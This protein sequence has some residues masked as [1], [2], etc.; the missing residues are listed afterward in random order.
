VRKRHSAYQCIDELCFQRNCPLVK[1]FQRL[2]ESLFEDGGPYVEL[3]R[4]IAKYRYGIG[5]AELIAKSQLPDGGYTVSRLHQLEKAGFITSLV[6]YGRKDKGLYYVIDDEYSLFYLYWMEPKSKVIS[7]K[8]I[9]QGFWLAQANQPAW[10]T[11]AAL[12]FESTCY[13]HIDQIHQ[14]LKID[15]GASSETWR[16]VPKTAQG[17]GAQIDLLFDGLD[18]AIT[19]CEIKYSEKPFAI[20]KSYAQEILKKMELFK[21]QTKTKKQ[22]F[23]SI[24]TTMGLKPTMYSEELISS[25]ATLDDLFKNI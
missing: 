23:F 18:G 6:S 22:L 5:Q 3:I 20:D 8:C 24:I 1:E 15:P 25:E 9:N 12:S 14:A 7:R 4:T 16:F 11:W 21:Q 17:E 13:K 10:K 19:L 2:F